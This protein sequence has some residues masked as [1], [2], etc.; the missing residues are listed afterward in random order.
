MRS[1]F[2]TTV[3]FAQKHIPANLDIH[4]TNATVITIFATHP[5]IGRK[6]GLAIVYLVQIT[7]LLCDSFSIL[8]YNAGTQDFQT[9]NECPLRAKKARVKDLALYPQNCK[10]FTSRTPIFQ[11]KSLHFL[12]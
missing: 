12:V 11:A 3:P 8:L 5:F 1:N 4:N 2:L 7:L 9:F 10:K 6:P